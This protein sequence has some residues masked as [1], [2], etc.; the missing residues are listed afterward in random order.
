LFLLCRDKVAVN[1]NCLRMN[2]LCYRYV[3]HNG[4]TVNERPHI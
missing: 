3:P 4:V 2:V 1:V